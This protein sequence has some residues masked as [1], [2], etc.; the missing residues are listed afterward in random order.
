MKK[1]Q[2][3]PLCYELRSVGEKR[4]KYHEQSAAADPESRESGKDKGDQNIEYHVIILF[5]KLFDY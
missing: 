5:K 4:Q 1:Q 3:H 2:I